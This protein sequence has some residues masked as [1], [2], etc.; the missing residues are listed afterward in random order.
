MGASHRVRPVVKIPEK[1]I[2]KQPRSIAVAVSGGPDSMA[3]LHLAQA[4]LP[5][6]KFH[7]LT[8]D[9]GL[10]K[11]SACEAERIGAWIAD[12]PRV[13]H[14]ILKWKGDKPESG[15]MEAARDARYDILCRWCARNG[16]SQLWVAHHAGDQAETFLFRLAHGSGVDGLGGMAAISPYRD[17]GIELIRPL[18]D[19]TKDEIVAYCTRA[20]I[21]FVTDP[22]NSNMKY[23]R[24]R[25]RH[26]LPLLEAEGLSEKRLARTAA[27]LRHAREALDYYADRIVKRHATIAP[28][29]ATIAIKALGAAPVDMRVRV[30]RRVI[31]QMGAGAYGPRLDRLEDLVD[32]VFDDLAAA[33]RFTLGGFV[34]T[35]DMKRNVFTITREKP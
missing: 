15:I 16:I 17:S 35:P 34:F 3:L 2:K 14:H 9:H 19:R 30:I 31:D 12:W 7:A 20:K 8:L 33:K 5:R 13:T 18:L 1:F 27:R 6:T 10:R 4:A 24:A 28:A 21:P 22:T 11:E 26:A 23:A 25:L 32:G 29:K